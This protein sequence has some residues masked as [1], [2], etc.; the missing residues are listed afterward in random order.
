Q[1]H[2]AHV[3]GCAAENGVAPPYLGVAWDDA[4]LGDDGAV[5]G[6]EFFRA[7]TCG[8][9]RV[10][11]L[12]PFRLLGGDAAARTG[13]RVAISMDWEARGAAE[14]EGR[15]DARVLAAMLTHGANAPWCTS[16]GRL[17]DAVAA[18]TGI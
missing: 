6:G 13:W 15:D 1:H 11:H 14:L 4:G 18:V 17:F 10:A 12:R 5:W 8:F 3:A 2:H 16:V 9:Q 7:G